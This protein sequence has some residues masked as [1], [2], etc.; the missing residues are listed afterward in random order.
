MRR[1]VGI[2]FRQSSSCESALE[3]IVR[4]CNIVG[5]LAQLC[6]RSFGFPDE[7]SQTFCMESET[8]SFQSVTDDQLS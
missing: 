1:V 2:Q 6:D 8:K 7:L 5:A 4:G 3:Q